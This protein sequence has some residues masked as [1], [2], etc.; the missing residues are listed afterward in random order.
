MKHDHTCHCTGEP[1][2][3]GYAF[4][5]ECS[6]KILPCERPG[7][8]CDPNVERVE[9]PENWLCL[10]L[11]PGVKVRVGKNVFISSRE[12]KRIKIAISADVSVR[13]DRI[14]EDGTIVKPRKPAPIPQPASG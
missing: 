11:R 8:Q 9:I 10:D 5:G 13:I 2:Q 14:N 7:G 6:H 12:N 3:Y 1:H 4:M